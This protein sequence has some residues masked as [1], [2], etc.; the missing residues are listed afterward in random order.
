MQI[1]VY[2]LQQV[3]I[4]CK[5]IFSTNHPSMLPPVRDRFPLFSEHHIPPIFL[6]IEY[7]AKLK[8]RR[9]KHSRHPF[10][11][12]RAPLWAAFLASDLLLQKQ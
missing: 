7:R 5:A 10:L 4:S 2:V 12:V 6:G 1:D 8:S 9:T 11:K 3:Q